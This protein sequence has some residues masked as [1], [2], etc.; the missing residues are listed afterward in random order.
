MVIRHTPRTYRNLIFN[1]YFINLLMPRC[2]NNSPIFVQNLYNL[3]TDFDQKMRQ[4]KYSD[5]YTQEIESK[6]RQMEPVNAH[7]QYYRSTDVM[8]CRNVPDMGRGMIASR[9]LNVGDIIV[10]ENDVLLSLPGDWDHLNFDFDTG[11]IKTSEKL[12]SNS[13]LVNK[14]LMQIA[15]H[16]MTPEDKQWFKYLQGYD[17]YNTLRTNIYGFDFDMPQEDGTTELEY[18]TVLFKAGSLINHSFTPNVKLMYKLPTDEDQTDALNGNYNEKVYYKVLQHIP[19]NSQIL[20]NYRPDD[21]ED[22]E[23]RDDL[24]RRIWGI[25]STK[26][27]E[28]SAEKKRKT[29]T[30]EMETETSRHAASTKFVFLV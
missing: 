26:G 24:F 30:T 6:V 15:D 5:T 23:A 9:D 7:A 12:T 2:K 20:V 19:A 8:E 4:L 3:F 16:Y 27:T 29:E 25:K 14:A 13:H 1:L 10:F 11:D 18:V 28:T 17:F 22:T 21:V